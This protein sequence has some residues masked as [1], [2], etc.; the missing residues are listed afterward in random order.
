MFLYVFVLCECVICLRF[1][2][3]MCLCVCV[4]SVC[5]R[6]YVLEFSSLHKKHQ[7]MQVVGREGK[8]EEVEFKR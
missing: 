3:Q 1:L 6:V 8:E 5:V 4:L 2:K 7:S